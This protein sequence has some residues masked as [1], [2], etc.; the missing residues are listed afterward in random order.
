MKVKLWT[1]LTSPALV[2]G[3]MQATSATSYGDVDEAL[4]VEQF[5]DSAEVRL[6]K[7]HNHLFAFVE[8][9]DDTLS[10]YTSNRQG[11][12]WRLVDET[13]TLAADLLAQTSQL[14]TFGVFETDL[15]AG[16]VNTSGIAEVWSICM[17]CRP[18]IWEQVGTTGLGD[19]NNT[20]IIDF[21]RIPDQGIYAITENENGNGLFMSEDGDAWTQVGDYGLGNQISDAVAASR[22]FV[23]GDVVNLATTAG[24]V[25]QASF[26]DLSTWTALETFDGNITAMLGRFVAV[27]A[28]GIVSVYESDANNTFNQVGA[29][30]LGNEANESVA[31]FVNIG[32]RPELIV[33]N[34]TEGTSYYKYTLQDDA[35]SVLIDGGFGSSANTSVTS[36]LHYHRDIYVSTV[37]TTAGP[38]IYKLTR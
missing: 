21:F 24:V 36:A 26:D 10:L 31:R 1:L 11:E 16:T 6:V 19:E 34:A 14:D 5:A 32:R 29:A 28:D 38:A 8:G 30:D 13:A 25:Y 22:V 17:H 12:E 4:L 27:T 3:L 9:A 18:A 7:H 15:Y 37:N 23:V 35:W 2:F 33:A 20:A